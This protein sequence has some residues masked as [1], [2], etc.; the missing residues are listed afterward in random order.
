MSER[1]LATAQKQSTAPAAPSHGAILQREFAYGNHAKAGGE[2]AE[3]S[4]TTLGLQ[5]KLTIGASSDP[6][7]L[8]ADRVAEAVVSGRSVATRPS[9]GPLAV[10]RQEMEKPR[11]QPQFPAQETS[12]TEKFQK[13]GLAAAGEFFRRFWDQFSN[14]E[15]GKR[16]LA[17]N[18][19][20]L[21]PIL[22][23]FKD[24]ADSIFGKTAPGAGGSAAA[25]SGRDTSSNPVNSPSTA[26]PAPYA[27]KDEKLFSLELKWDFVT[28]PSGMTLKTPWLDSPEIPLGPTPSTPT[29]APPK[30][31]LPFKMA[32]KIPRICTPA[33]PQGD[34]G[35][36]DARSAFIFWWLQQNQQAAEKRA[37]EILDQSKL[38]APPKFAP[39][40]VKPLFK[41][42][43]GAKAIPD[44]QPV[45]AGLRSPGKPLDPATRAFMEQ[46]FGYDFSQVRVH[47]DSKAAE[48][49]RALNAMAYTFGRDVVFGPGRYSP[50]T[51]SGTKL[52]AHELTHVVQ[53]TGSKANLSGPTD[54]NGEPSAIAR[55]NPSP[56][57]RFGPT[58]GFLVQ[59]SPDTQGDT[60]TYG[61]LSPRKPDP[62][63]VRER[64]EL[65]KAGGSWVE[66]AAGGEQKP[67]NGAYS[68]ALRDGRMYGSRFG[69]LEAS[70]GGRVRFVGDIQFN[71]GTLERWDAGSG[72]Y[73][74]VESFVEEIAA[75]AKKNGLDLEFDRDPQKSKFRP[76]APEAKSGQRQ[77]PVIQG[78]GDAKAEPPGKGA[79]APAG[80]ASQAAGGGG[81]QPSAAQPL[82][83]VTQE[84]R[85][86][87]R[88]IAQELGKSFRLM[89]VARVLTSILR[90]VEFAGNLVMVYQSISMAQ[91]GLAGEGFILTDK[92]KESEDLRDK[93]NAL[94]AEYPAYSDWVQSMGFPIYVAAVDADS[95]E[96]LVM[97]LSELGSLIS[98]QWVDLRK[99]SKRVKSA[100]KEVTA[101]RQAAKKI[102]DD[103]VA[104]AALDHGGSTLNSATVLAADMD[105]SRIESAL[106]QTDKAW[107]SVISKMNADIDFVAAWHSW[108]Q[109][110]G[111]ASG[112]LKPTPTISVSAGE[113]K[114]LSKAQKPQDGL[115]LT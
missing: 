63:L 33:D 30:A 20:D 106:M 29:P 26:G 32:P 78:K 15:E 104:L 3:C 18:E 87:A 13:G 22:K 56:A 48:S 19:R 109:D 12:E 70:G 95:I 67:A 108:L 61:S 103:P 97:Q 10:Q 100:L 102:L 5:R 83:A 107:D 114:E 52:L 86:G 93:A 53:Q 76:L 21:Q 84:M 113:L 115:K 42:E 9:T 88:D 66:I 17:K 25:K 43:A 91:R 79:Q 96:S 47:T 35:E 54:R 65:K 37:Q 39:S 7:E 92:I 40:A 57:Q 110:V 74:P 62:N 90:V 34:Q 6:L 8:E 38:R 41:R 31:P 49:A 27:A 11:E 101:K 44:P 85:A 111:V 89:R 99:Q 60:P 75:E 64:V 24:F 71:N 73:K 80:A 94:G 28:P 16:I 69:H 59:R 23:F 55:N 51:S 77:L 2:Y 50:M 68:F 45:E 105:L 1:A 81:M 98:E 36:A 14:S 58:S 46:R 72:S 4:K 82:S 112:K